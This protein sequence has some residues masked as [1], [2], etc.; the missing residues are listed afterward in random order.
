MTRKE[1]KKGKQ[2]EWEGERK[3]FSA[4]VNSTGIKVGGQVTQKNCPLILQDTELVILFSTSA[5]PTFT[6]SIMFS[7]EK[8]SPQ[9]S[10]E[11]D[12][13]FTVT[14]RG[15]EISGQE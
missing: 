13:S 7:L 12:I 2:V 11:Y 3:R 14:M 10:C 4:Q 6:E 9:S 8:I 5:L 15:S 1:G